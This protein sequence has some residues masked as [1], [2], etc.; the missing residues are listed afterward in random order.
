MIYALNIGG[1]V[2]EIDRMIL[3]EVLSSNWVI[4]WEKWENLDNFF[5]TELI[6]V[7]KALIK[8]PHN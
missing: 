1:K 4:K 2:K 8:T 5:S 6:Q 7:G 3:L